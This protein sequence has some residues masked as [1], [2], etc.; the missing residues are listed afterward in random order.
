MGASVG[1]RI[2]G[3]ERMSLVVSQL[4]FATLGGRY[5]LSAGDFRGPVTGAAGTRYFEPDGVI[6][7]VSTP[8]QKTTVRP[9]GNADE[10]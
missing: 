3:V 1:W 9:A 6:F 8:C 2:N 4:I 5:S 10:R 7:S